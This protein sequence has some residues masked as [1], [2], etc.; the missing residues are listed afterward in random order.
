MPRILIIDDH[1]LFADMLRELVRI[2]DAEAQV[3]TAANFAAAERA[4]KAGEPYDLLLLDLNMPGVSGMSAFEKLK[5]IRPETPIAIV[6]GQA[7]LSDIRNALK[8]GA[9]GF[10]P[11]T[12]KSQ[13]F[14]NALRLMLSGGRYIPDAML[15]NEDEEPMDE[16]G[17]LTPR[18][19]DVFEA[20]MG[21]R[22]NTEIAT[23]LQLSEATVKMHMQHI[24]QKIGARN[25]GDAIRIGLLRGNMENY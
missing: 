1:L 7:R 13:V 19:N 10:L 14:L 6:S 9:A 25:R 11:K 15:A 8:A 2:I 22:S 18:E 20:L 24:F 12:I 17:Q 3:D 4:L 16:K 5:A 23:M 21:G